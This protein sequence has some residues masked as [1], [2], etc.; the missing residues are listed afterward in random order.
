MD[1]ASRI[2]EIAARLAPELVA[3]RRQLHQHPELAFEEH[4]TAK[5]VTRFLEKAGLPVKTGIGRTGVVAVLEGAKPGRTIGIRADMDAL[6]IHED[7]GLAFASK[8]PGK[9]HACGHDVHTVTVLGAAAVLSELREGLAGRIKFIFQPAEETL[10]GAPAM[11]ADGVLDD[12]RLD[13]ILGFHNWPAVEAGK[14]GFRHGTVMASADAFDLTLKGKAGHGAHPHRAIDAV[15]AGAHF[16]TQLQTIVSREVAPLSPA[17]ITVGEFHS[18][19]ARNIVAATATLK[20]SVRTQEPGLSEAIEAAVRRLLE[21]MRAGMRVDY[22]LDWKRLTPVLRQNEPVLATVLASARAMLGAH[23]VVELDQASMGSEDFAWFAEKV[24]AAHLRIGSR[25]EG[26][27]TS[28]HHANY[29]CNEAAIGVG[30]RVLARA[31]LDLAGER[32]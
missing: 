17:V 18:G 20:G 2:A 29:D 6:P 30:V 23:N 22:E 1:P 3:L 10:S 25:I 19:T 15:V 32:R 27:E 12:P 9:M 24:P 13:A 7:T 4:Q 31:A 14:V 21:G 16:V 26:L 28:I 8:V 5:A 11:I